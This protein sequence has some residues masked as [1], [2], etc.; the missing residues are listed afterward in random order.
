MEKATTKPSPE[1]PASRRRRNDPPLEKKNEVNDEEDQKGTNVVIKNTAGDSTNEGWG[2]VW[3]KVDEEIKKMNESTVTDIRKDSTVRD[4][5]ESENRDLQNCNRNDAPRISPNGAKNMEDTTRN[6][7]E[8][9]IGERE[10]EEIRISENRN[11]G[12]D[13]EI[14]NTEIRHTE[15]RNTE[16]RKSS[17]DMEKRSEEIPTESSRTQPF[18]DDASETETKGD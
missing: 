14:R 7:M 4:V 18:E 6:N 17:G 16:K 1:S 15:K 3:V 5:T 13:T 11:S 9:S 8:D 12:D 2:Q 10:N